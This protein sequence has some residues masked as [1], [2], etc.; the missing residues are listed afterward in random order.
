MYTYLRSWRLIREYD[1]N[2][3]RLLILLLRQHNDLHLPQLQ[4]AFSLWELRASSKGAAFLCR[5]IFSFEHDQWRKLDN[6]EWTASYHVR[7]IH[8][9]HFPN[10][11]DIKKGHREGLMAARSPTEALKTLIYPATVFA[12]GLVYRREQSIE[13]ELKNWL[14]GILEGTSWDPERQLQIQLSEKDVKEFP[15]RM[16]STFGKRSVLRE[17]ILK[18]QT[19]FMTF[20]GVRKPWGPLPDRFAAFWKLE[21]DGYGSS[22]VAVALYPMTRPQFDAAIHRSMATGINFQIARPDR[23]PPLS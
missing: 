14:D 8:G 19:L 18:S 21:G 6:I 2:G 15:Q 12:N 1:P 5:G 9:E 23:V 22:L 20:H 4:N 7:I 11:L 3:E 10:I 17:V 16:R 13:S